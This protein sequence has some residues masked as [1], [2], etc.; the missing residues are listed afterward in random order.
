M[1]NQN[2]LSKMA[3]VKV[4]HNRTTVLVAHGLTTIRNA[5]M[6]SVVTWA[7]LWRMVMSTLLLSHPISKLFKNLVLEKSS[8][9]NS[10]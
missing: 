7:K 1:P 10:R 6:I 9:R 5:D 3:L 8:F 4:M 2:T